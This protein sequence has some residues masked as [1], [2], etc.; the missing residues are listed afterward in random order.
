MN[1]DSSGRAQGHFNGEAHA[2]EQPIR[3]AGSELGA[4]RHI[5]AFFH[6]AEEEYRVLLPF[7]KEGFERGEKAFHIVDPELHDEHLRQLASAD[8]GTAESM[9]SGQLE[10]RNWHEAYLREGH[11]DQDKMLTL[12]QEVLDDARQQGFPLTRI[13]TH[14]EWPLEDRADLD[15]VVEYETKLNYLWQQYKD[16]V[17]CVYDIARFGGDVI[18][19]VMRT[20]PVTIIGGILQENPFFVPPDEFLRELNERAATRKGLS[21]QA[22]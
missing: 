10:M 8:I 3:L 7:I 15:D 22:G 20:H 13:V 19:D 1:S 16:P 9:Q 4:Q 18:V 17:I 21:E 14:M 6:S 2:L 5:C 11:F 12:L